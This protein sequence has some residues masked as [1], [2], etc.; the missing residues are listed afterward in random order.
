MNPSRYFRKPNGEPVN[1]LIDAVEFNFEGDNI[2]SVRH[3]RNGRRMADS[4]W[5]WRDAM[6]LVQSGHWVEVA[7]DRDGGWREPA[8]PALDAPQ[9]TSD[10]EGGAW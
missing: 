10:L 6:S 5:R 2:K 1:D 3:M 9:T 8:D 4:A 7:P